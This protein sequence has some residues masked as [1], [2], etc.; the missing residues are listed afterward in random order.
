[1]LLSGEK[2]TMDGKVICPGLFLAENRIEF[3][4][5]HMDKEYEMCG[6]IFRAFKI[7]SYSSFTINIS[8]NN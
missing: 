8:S 1:M 6:K 7:V 2:L 4:D 3:K 5:T